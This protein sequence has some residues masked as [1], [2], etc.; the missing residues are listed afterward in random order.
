MTFQKF[1]KLENQNLSIII[2]V[3]SPLIQ[4]KPAT[5][6]VYPEVSQ[7]KG[8]VL[9]LGAFYI[10]SS[11]YLGQFFSLGVLMFDI[12]IWMERHTNTSYIQNLIHSEDLIWAQL[13][14]K[15]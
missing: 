11:L 14:I 6:F 9:I 12:P 5:Y 3:L 10:V 7:L 1:T 4:W 15:F 13:Y 2:V 8:C